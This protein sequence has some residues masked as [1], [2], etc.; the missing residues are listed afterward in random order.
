MESSRSCLCGSPLS[1]LRPDCL[2]K[3]RNNLLPIVGI[4]Y[5]YD[6]LS[7]LVDSLHALI[8]LAIANLYVCYLL[9][10]VLEHTP[11]RRCVLLAHEEVLHTLLVA[12]GAV[13]G[14]VHGI[15]TGNV[16]CGAGVPAVNL[17]ALH[18]AEYVPLEHFRGR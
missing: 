11:M 6:I 8:Q 15:L 12:T 18:L 3:E 17:A 7:V 13:V 9:H 14:S 2:G 1:V 4:P 10:H 16:P 5:Q